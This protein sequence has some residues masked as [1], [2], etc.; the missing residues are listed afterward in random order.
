MNPI[1]PP[2]YKT[3]LPAGKHASF[4][5][6]RGLEIKLTDEHGDANVAM[7]LYNAENLLERYN[8]PDNT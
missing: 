3:Y 4:R 7:V 5:L 6:R 1:S 8:A 2:H